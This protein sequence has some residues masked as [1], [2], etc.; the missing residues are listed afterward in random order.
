[1]KM[2][3]KVLKTHCL[4]PRTGVLNAQRSWDKQIFGVRD[5][6]WE[7][8]PPSKQFKAKNTNLLVLEEYPVGPSLLHLKVLKCRLTVKN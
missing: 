3:R 6:E 8:N 7:D 1:M 4:G 5:K 2:R